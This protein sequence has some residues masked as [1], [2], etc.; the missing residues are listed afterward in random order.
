MG[1]PYS[2]RF[3]FIPKQWFNIVALIEDTGVRYYCNVASPMYVTGQVLTYID[4]DLDVIRM[5]DR[6]VHIV[7]QDEYERHKLNYHYSTLVESKVNDGLAAILNWRV[8][9][10]RHFKMKW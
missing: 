10:S 7:D 6:S 5:P 8:R 3:F 1:Q 2:G 9:I 4:Y